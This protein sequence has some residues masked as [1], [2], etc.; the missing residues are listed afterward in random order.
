MHFF[1]NSF[2]LINCF[3]FDHEKSNAWQIMRNGSSQKECRLCILPVRIDFYNWHDLHNVK[4][5]TWLKASRPVNLHPLFLFWKHGSVCD[6]VKKGAKCG[7]QKAGC[8]KNRVIV[9][10]K[11]KKPDLF[12]KFQTLKKNIRPTW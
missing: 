8:K 3:C 9:I 2:Q 4:I 11:E 12:L 7:L 5:R 10:Q 6:P 1:L